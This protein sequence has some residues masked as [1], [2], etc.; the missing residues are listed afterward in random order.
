MLV[1]FLLISQMT[2]AQAYPV[3]VTILGVLL[4]KYEAK[5][6][7]AHVI[8]DTISVWDAKDILALTAIEIDK[9]RQLQEVIVIDYEMAVLE[10]GDTTRII[11]NTRKLSREMTERLSKIKPGAKLYFEGIRVLDPKYG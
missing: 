5:D 7:G 9:E 8:L 4:G 1:V 3:A 10:N 2:N 6:N 11:N